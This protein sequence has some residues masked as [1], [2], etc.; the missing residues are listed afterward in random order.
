M[1]S[2]L[3]EDRLTRLRALSAQAFDAKKWQIYYQIPPV[4]ALAETKMTTLWVVRLSF[5]KG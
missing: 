3:I 5:E 4:C 2:E 1:D